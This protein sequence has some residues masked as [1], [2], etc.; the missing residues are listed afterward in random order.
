MSGSTVC[1]SKDLSGGVLQFFEGSFYLL[2]LVAGGE[3]LLGLCDGIGDG[4]DLVW[5]E[6]F[7]LG[8]S[9]LDVLN[10]ALSSVLQSC[11]Y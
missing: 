11:E 8:H 4:G 9:L 7:V 10:I 6:G 1:G 3:H 2:L 5:R